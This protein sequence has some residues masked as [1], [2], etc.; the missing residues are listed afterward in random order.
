MQ[1]IGATEVRKNW[2]SI[3]DNVVR[4]RPNVIKRTRDYLFLSTREDILAM[5]SGVKCTVSTIHENDGSYTLATD[6]MYLA[7]NA[8]TENQAL[9]NLAA[10]ILEYAIEYYDNYQLYSRSPNR[11]GH[12]PYVT[13]AFLLDDAERIKEEMLCHDG[14]N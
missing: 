4:V 3:C 1:T 6:E 5:L 10:S 8:D 12:L 13:K 7:E 11:S 2:S 9:M 14:K